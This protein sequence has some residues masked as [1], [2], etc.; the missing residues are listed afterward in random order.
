MISATH[1]NKH[2]IFQ[3][4]LCRS[5]SAVAACCCCCDQVARTFRR[6]QA[7]AVTNPD[8]IAA[9][10]AAT[11]AEPTSLLNVPPATFP[12]FT[13]TRQWLLLLDASC[14]TSFFARTPEGHMVGQEIRDWDGI[15]LEVELGD[16]WLEDEVED[17]GDDD[18]DEGGGSGDSDYDEAEELEE[19]RARGLEGV[20][21]GGWVDMPFSKEA[22]IWV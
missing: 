14:A 3:I 9:I 16:D 19:V 10:A 12:L 4:L 15:G 22:K 1:T 2:S 20:W 11:A 6:L 8:D 18:G 17:E 21:P 13:T 7:A 5:A